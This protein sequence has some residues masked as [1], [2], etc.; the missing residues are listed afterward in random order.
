MVEL[1]IHYAVFMAPD[2]DVDTLVG[3]LVCIELG[4]FLAVPAML[5]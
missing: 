4:R 3:D 1:A 5:E 2:A